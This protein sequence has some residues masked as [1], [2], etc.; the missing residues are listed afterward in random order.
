MAQGLGLD[1]EWKFLLK[2]VFF[3]FKTFIFIFYFF[4][5]Y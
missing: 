1:Y 2:N 4:I 5:I 3:F